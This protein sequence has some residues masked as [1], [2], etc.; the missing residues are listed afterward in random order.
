[1]KKILCLLFFI[2]VSAAELYARAGGSG[3]GHSSGGGFHSGGGSGGFHSSG[4]GLSTGAMPH[5]YGGGSSVGLGSSAGFIFM[6]FV[7]AVGVLLVYVFFVRRVNTGFSNFPGATPKEFTDI[8]GADAF[9]EANPD[10][11]EDEFLEKAKKAFMDIQTAWSAGDIQPAR[12]FLSDGVYQRFNTQI[13][14]MNLL[15]QKDVISDVSVTSIFVDRIDTDGLFDVLNVAINAAM[16]DQFVCETNHDLD[17]PGGHEN[18]T[19]YWSFMRKRGKGGKDIFFTQNCPS[20]G[21]P[22]PENMGDAGNCPYCK[23]FVN[24]G[25]YDWVLSEIT[26]LDDYAMNSYRRDKSATLDGAV[27]SIV[28]DDPDFSVQLVEDKASNGYLQIQTAIAFREPARMRRFVSD[29]LYGKITGKM[30]KHHIVFNRLYLNDVSLTAVQSEGDMYRLFI[31]VKSS[32][33]RA[34]IEDSR[35]EMLDQLVMTKREVI[36]MEKAKGAVKSKG[37][38]YAHLCPSCGAPAADSTDVKCGYCGAVM[39][40]PK[41]EWIITDIMDAD[42]YNAA[43]TDQEQSFEAKNSVDVEDSLY[44]N[45]DFAF[46]NALVIFGADGVFSDE[47]KAMADKLAKKWRFNKDYVQQMI[48]AAAAKRLSIRMPMDT[49]KCRKIFEL[50]KKAAEADGK[51]SPEEQEILDSVYKEYCGN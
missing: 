44:K 33:Q 38:A 8:P 5:Y 37:S 32:Y 24:S 46:N 1:M 43:V 42:G 50:M 11:D 21:A 28:K 48:S 16:S 10:F 7:I 34:A 19:E 18:F 41:T 4:S 22:L 25:E 51:I 31:S 39:N 2:A 35:S 45:R 14:M 12:R 15:K 49:A 30:P 27:E 17:S 13:A 20:C 26:Q 23:A 47:E 29:A 6:F 36:V 9:L 3:G 40:S